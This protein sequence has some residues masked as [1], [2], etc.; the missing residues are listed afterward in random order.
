MK[1]S[2][3][4]KLPYLGKRMAKLHFPPFSATYSNF[5]QIRSQGVPNFSE[6]GSI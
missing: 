1:I 5:F 4:I 6:N 2:E 3:I